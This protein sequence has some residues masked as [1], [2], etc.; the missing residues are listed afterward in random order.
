MSCSLSLWADRIQFSNH[1]DSAQYSILIDQDIRH[2]YPTLP[3]SRNI[4]SPPA[5]GTDRRSLN[6]RYLQPWIISHEPEI[7]LYH[8]TVL[9]STVVRHQ[10]CLISSHYGKPPLS[11][12]GD[13]GLLGSIKGRGF[14]YP[15]SVYTPFK[16]R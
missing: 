4:F 8:H 16:G 12:D 10:Q 14:T 7:G 2:I 6:I 5:T 11:I 13:D 1:Q 3:K 9:D 15:R